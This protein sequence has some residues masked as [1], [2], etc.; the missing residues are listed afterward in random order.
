MSTG[1]MRG[2]AEAWNPWDPSR[3]KPRGDGIEPLVIEEGEVRRSA[4]RIILVAFVAF[5]TW[6]SLAP[7]DGGVV[8]TGTVT[9]SGNRKAVQHPTGGVVQELMVREGATVREGEVVLRVNP[10]NTE[11]SL[12]EVELQYINLLATESR[13]IAERSGNDIVWKP[14]L[15]RFGAKD[16]RVAEAKLLQT[17]LIATRRAELDSQTRILREQLAGQE[18][19]ARSLEKVILEKRSQLT[20]IAQ[21]ARNVAQLAKEGYVPEAK[22]NE[23]ARAQ[24]SM[25]GDLANLMGEVTRNES[26]MAATRLQIAQQRTAFNREIENQLSEIQKNREAYLTRLQS[27]TFDRRLMEVRAPVSGTVVGLK[28]NTV[29]GV[30]T[31]SQVL[32]EIVPRDSHLIVEAKVP[33]VSIDKV[34]QGLDADLRFSAFNQRVTP[35]IP[36]RVRLVGADKLSGPNAGEEYY[37]AQVEVTPQGFELLGEKRIQAGMPVDVIVKTG[38][39]SFMS[40]L[41]KPLTDRFAQAFKEE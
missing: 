1:F 3:L 30:I 20:L 12:T 4:L 15:N 27:R 23:V 8:M 22:A 11:A 21:E 34:R 5:F 19:Q 6:A 35:I 40:Y 17:Q 32:M 14:E 26:A 25:Q 39:R 29:G 31:G 36:G 41:L 13:L 18:A 16:L 9:V 7:I 24:S 38:E 10:L 28:V 37:L 2:L 33:P